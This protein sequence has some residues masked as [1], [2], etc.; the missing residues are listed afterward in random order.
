M[1]LQIGRS[2]CGSISVKQ[3]RIRIAIIDES[4]LVS[5]SVFMLDQIAKV[6]A[7]KTISF[8]GKSATPIVHFARKPE[9]H[10]N[11]DNTTVRRVESIVMSENSV[12]SKT[13][14]HFGQLHKPN[15]QERPVACP[16]PDDAF[17]MIGSSKNE[18]YKVRAV[19]GSCELVRRQRSEF[20]CLAAE[21]EWV[22]V[23][24]SDA[25]L[26]VFK[27]S[28]LK[29][30]EYFI[31]TFAK[32]VKCVAVNSNH[33]ALVCGTCDETIL[34]C[35]LLD[36]EIIR[37]VKVEG[38]RPILLMITSGWGFVVTYLTKL[39]NG[40]LTHHLA[41]YSINGDLIRTK[42]IKFPV[43]AWNCTK[44]SDGFDY[45]FLADDCVNFYC[46][47]AFYL[48]IDQ[49]FYGT[50]DVVMATHFIYDDS[51]AIAVTRE[52]RVLFVPLPK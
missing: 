49:R 31:P 6:S 4:G 24:D 44:S 37:V 40:K 16:L 21:G 14:K 5:T 8:P 46:F 32:C 9:R 18:L 51:T 50:N 34:F 28:N 3:E 47:E 29:T 25:V 27:T 22:A 12:S 52:G 23:S 42:E 30:P 11:G 33:R 2:L 45:V 1:N 39:E 43:I 10:S 38:Y 7:G 13:L 19:T 35:S 20:V 48:N 41:L 15:A 26:S 36:G 17:L